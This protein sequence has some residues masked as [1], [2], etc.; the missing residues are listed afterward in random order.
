[1]T[2][3]LVAPAEVCYYLLS[4]QGF[5]FILS[6]YNTGFYGMQTVVPLC[7]TQKQQQKKQLLFM[8]PEEKSCSV[9]W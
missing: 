7:Y 5:R 3:M 9:V 6:F 1:M 8:V 2:I 4:F